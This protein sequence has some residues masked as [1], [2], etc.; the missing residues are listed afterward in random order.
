MRAEPEDG[1]ARY[2]DSDLHE[3]RQRGQEEERPQGSL[4]GA[5]QRG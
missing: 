1:L 2:R 4:G 5:G 3:G